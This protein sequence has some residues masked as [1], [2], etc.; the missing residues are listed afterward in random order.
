MGEFICEN[1]PGICSQA[2]FDHDVAATMEKIRLFNML[3]KKHNYSTHLKKRDIVDLDVF[4][5][6]VAKDRFYRGLD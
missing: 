3:A 1:P 5:K 4:S 6:R 2:D